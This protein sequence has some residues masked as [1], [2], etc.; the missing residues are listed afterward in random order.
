MGGTNH[1]WLIVYMFEAVFIYV[2][3]TELKE[4]EAEFTLVGWRGEPALS[5]SKECAKYVQFLPNNVGD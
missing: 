2:L 5:R 3:V 4:K 1:K